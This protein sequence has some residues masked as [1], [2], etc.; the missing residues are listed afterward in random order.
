MIK[1]IWL[2]LFLLFLFLILNIIITFLHYWDQFIQFF[3]FDITSNLSLLFIILNLNLNFFLK[4]AII[5][6]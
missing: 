5:F 3:N 2:L 4:Y 6:N 1:F